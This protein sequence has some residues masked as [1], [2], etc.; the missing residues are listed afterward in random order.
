MKTNN[1]HTNRQFTTTPTGQLV[2]KKRWDI[3]P[4][5][6]II[7]LERDAM[8]REVAT[9]LLCSP[10]VKSSNR[11]RKVWNE[12]RATMFASTRISSP[13]QQKV[14]TRLQSR[15][16]QQLN[17][18]LRRVTERRATTQRHFLF[19]K[20]QA[21]KLT[22]KDKPLLVLLERQMASLDLHAAGLDSLREAVDEEVERRALFCEHLRTLS[23]SVAKKLRRSLC[24]Y[25]K[26][27]C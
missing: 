9:E 4:P 13:E 6:N 16:W 26:K 21:E 23:P 1:K 10:K 22:E 18:L 7:H 25:A 15:S 14:A 20:K 8:P 11:E 5:S 3:A 2:R 17:T 12:A 27:G 19:L 24:G